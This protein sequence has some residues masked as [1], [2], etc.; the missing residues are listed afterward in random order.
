MS[1][2]ISKTSIK[3]QYKL[4]PHHQA[5]VSDLLPR[6]KTRHTCVISAETCIANAIRRVLTD[7]L[8]V[9]VLHTEIADIDTDS[10]ATHDQIQT[11]L[12]LC[13]ITQEYE[14]KLVG[15]LDFKNETSENRIITTHDL[16]FER[17]IHANQVVDK[18]PLFNLAPL[19]FVK[20]NKIKSVLETGYD[21]VGMSV[22]NILYRELSERK[23]EI[24]YT[25]NHYNKDR[26]N[27]A[28]DNIIE[29]L[30]AI[31]DFLNKKSESLAMYLKIGDIN[32]LSVNNESHT[33]GELI[34]RYIYLADKSCDFVAYR[35]EHPLVRRIIIKWR[36]SSG[37][38]I[39]L[40][41]IDNARKDLELLKNKK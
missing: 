20:I 19:R 35:Q 15:S 33:I 21:G 38:K 28:I 31:A 22:E 27:D 29:R 30:T 39:A 6:E 14:D 7:E 11:Q 13:P 37:V 40:T 4:L 9:Y 34:N 8:P 18:I 10:E 3:L 12:K 25:V 23:Y 5:L 36:H 32:E 16:K 26:W 17:G 41:A 2:L 24:S 1:K